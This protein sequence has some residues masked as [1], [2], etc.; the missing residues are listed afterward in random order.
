MN[1]CAYCC[2]ISQNNRCP[3]C[4][5]RKMRQV[6]NDD[7]CFL[8]ENDKSYCETLQQAFEEQNIRCVGMPC[9]NDL[10]SRLALPMSKCRLYVVYECFAAACDIIK[11]FKNTE[12]ENL[13]K[14][15]FENRE[16]IIFLPKTEK[17]IGKKLRLGEEQDLSAY[18]LDVVGR[19]SEISDEGRI[20]GCV[21]NG[22][23]IFCYTQNETLCLNSATYEILSLTLNKK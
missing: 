13:R 23:Y 2:R 11:Q 21:S 9:G 12:T 5:Y 4:G 8:L 19:A 6:E 15:I 7:F 20:S 3:Y 22:H 1:Y 16:K 14:N 18:C 17:K 10:D